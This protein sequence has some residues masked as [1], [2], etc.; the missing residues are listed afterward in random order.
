MVKYFYNAFIKY[1]SRDYDNFMLYF[2]RKST[3][4][5]TILLFH[6]ML[7]V[8]SSPHA[9]NLSVNLVD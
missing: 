5:K 8:V 4:L 9:Y 3:N 2:V 7:N 6:L 1:A